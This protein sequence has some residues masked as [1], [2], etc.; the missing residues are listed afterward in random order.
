MDIIL[1]LVRQNNK[2]AI[3]VFPLSASTAQRVFLQVAAM[4]II[5]NAIHANMDI[6]DKLME[7]VLIVLQNAK[8]A[9][10]I[11]IVLHASLATQ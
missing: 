9:I 5:L 10:L 8:L 2:I 11:Q 4:E 7:V 3:F 1:L 6:I